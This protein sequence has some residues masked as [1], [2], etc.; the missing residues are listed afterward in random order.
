MARRA[1]VTKSGT[2]ASCTATANATTPA[3]DRSYWATAHEA[4][5]DWSML[6]GLAFLLGVGAGPWSV[7][8]RLVG[9]SA[10]GGR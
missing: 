5:A 7:D 6:L 3:C 10:R 8:A 1:A 4:R 9:S 2:D